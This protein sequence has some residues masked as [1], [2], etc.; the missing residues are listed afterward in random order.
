MNKTDYI[1]IDL[2]VNRD[3]QEVLIAVLAESGFEAFE[4]TSFG[5]RIYQQES[6]FIEQSLVDLISPFIGKNPAMQIERI[7][8]RNW[9]T[10][11][12]KNYESVEIEGFCQIVP[13]FREAREGFSHTIYLDPRM[14]FGTGHHATTQL[15]IT[16]MKS[17]DYKDKLVLDMG[18]GTGVLAIL[19][20]KM[21]A[22]SIFAIDIDE[23][24]YENTLENVERNQ[25]RE[26]KVIQGAKEVIPEMNFDFILANINRN[27]LIEDIPHYRK[28][29]NSGGILLLSGFYKEDQSLIEKRCMEQSLQV[30]HVEERN[31]WIA[32]S[33][34]AK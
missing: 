15:M 31:R 25:A 2:D 3:Q 24:A 5:L 33:C 18:C 22:S 16:L 9:N 30:V 17:L 26:I 13:S 14:A 12:E 23:W 28:K 19:A 4:E 6:Q 1:Q 11:W 7:P 29:M 8:D 32:V 27:I 20:A 34:V 21:G 10:E